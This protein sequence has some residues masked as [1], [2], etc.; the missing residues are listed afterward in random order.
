MGGFIEAFHEGG[1]W[2]YLILV[3]GVFSVSIFLE[4]V[5]YLF[6]KASVDKDRF[7]ANVQRAILAGDLNSAVNYCSERSA[8]LTNIVRQG[9]IAVMNKGKEDEVQT[10][11]DVASLREVP[12]I[13]RRTSFLPLFANIATLLGLLATIVAMINAFKSVAAVD[14]S[15]KATMLSGAISEAMFGT[16]GGLIVAIP[17]LLAYAFLA[18]KTQRIL[19]DIHEVSVATLNLIL[20]NREKFSK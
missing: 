15:Q 7:L 3:L 10:A 6:G 19:D 12:L 11:M 18:S 17:S 8:P 20:Q 4:R 2:M 1:I 14:P 5:V 13:E 16:A 9:L